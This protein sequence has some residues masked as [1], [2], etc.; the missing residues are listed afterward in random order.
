MS[1]GEIRTILFVHV[2]MVKLSS[3]HLRWKIFNLF[4]IRSVKRSLDFVKDLYQ[5]VLHD[6]SLLPN[7]I[8]AYNLTSPIT[9][10]ITTAS[11]STDKG[12]KHILPDLDTNDE[13]P[14]TKKNRLITELS[15]IE[16]SGT[17]AL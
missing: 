12:K 8:P 3:V 10:D 7:H 16:M 13:D 17:N 6:M 9:N 4:L 1:N 11:T 15:G 2:S 14:N 5:L